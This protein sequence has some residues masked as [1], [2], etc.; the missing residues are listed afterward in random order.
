MQWMS[1][2]PAR[3]KEE[4]SATDKSHKRGARRADEARRVR[5]HGHRHASTRAARATHC[6]GVQRAL[7]ARVPRAPIRQAAARAWQR[8][9]GVRFAALC[10]RHVHAAQNQ[11]QTRRQAVQVEP[12]AYAVRQRRRRLPCA[13]GAGQRSAGARRSERN[14]NE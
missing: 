14:A 4:S 3:A 10:V 8:T 7:H 11:L 2:S 1:T 13:K 12:V 6:S 5:T 9:V